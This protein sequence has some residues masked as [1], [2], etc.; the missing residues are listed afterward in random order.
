M[1]NYNDTNARTYYVFEHRRL[2]DQI[3]YEQSKLRDNA[4]VIGALGVLYFAFGGAGNKFLKE[5][6]MLGAYFMLGSAYASGGFMVYKAIQLIKNINEK[7]N[8]KLE[9]SELENKMHEFGIPLDDEIG[10]HRL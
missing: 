7:A 9:I 3:N 6:E 5:E 4:I 1:K 10:G 2:E 8:L